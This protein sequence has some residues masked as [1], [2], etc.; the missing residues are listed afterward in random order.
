MS[1]D[2]IKV[3]SLEEVEVA[4]IPEAE[5]L[6]KHLLGEASGVT[7][8]ED[9]FDAE[10]AADVLRKLAKAT[11]ECESARKEV[12]APVLDLGKR[13]DAVAKEFAGDLKEHEQRISRLLGSYEAEQRKLR[14][15]AEA[16]TTGSGQARS[17]QRRRGE[18]QGRNRIAG[19]IRC[20]N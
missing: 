7:T 9:A 17:C 2:L 15:E 14:M 3:G 6:K 13:I 4:L 20:G 5:D 19:T 11:R 10:C 12:K 16:G 8:V 1:A 18:G